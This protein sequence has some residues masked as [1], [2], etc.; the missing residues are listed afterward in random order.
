MV[1][2]YVVSSS[3]PSYSKMTIGPQRGRQGDDICKLDINE[4]SAKQT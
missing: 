2:M 3:Q 4:W 1:G